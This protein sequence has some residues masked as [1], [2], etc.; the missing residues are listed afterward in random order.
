MNRT[1]ATAFFDE[2][3]KI[4]TIDALTDPAS[5]PLEREVAPVHREH[6]ALT[7]LKGIGGFAVGA[8]LGYTG[9]HYTDKAIKALGGDGVP[10]PVLRYGAP[11]V[12]AATG[13][14]FG[15]LQH[16][17]TERMK[18]YWAPNT[19]APTYGLDEDTGR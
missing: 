19:E 18:N 11:L 7:A 3:I 5:A 9:A 12:G 16:K 8:G 1:A 13:L 15:L 14:G 17:M 10:L 2:F 6:P 4:A